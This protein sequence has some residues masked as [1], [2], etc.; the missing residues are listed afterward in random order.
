MDQEEGD[1]CAGDRRTAWLEQ[2][3]EDG[4]YYLSR[5][6]KTLSPGQNLAVKEK[7]D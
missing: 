2:K 4:V 5:H 6:A 1:T 3:E 7:A